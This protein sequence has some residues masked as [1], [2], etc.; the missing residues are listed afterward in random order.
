MNFKVL[1]FFVLAGIALVFFVFPGCNW[2]ADNPMFPRAKIRIDAEVV[3]P[4]ASSEEKN[5][6]LV[7]FTFT[8]LN[9]VGARITQYRLEYRKVDG[10]PLPRLASTVGTN[11]DII[12]PGTPMASNAGLEDFS[13]IKEIDLLPPDVEAYLKTNRIP[14]VIVTVT[15]SGVD[16]A[17]H[18]VSYRGGEFR[19]NVFESLP[20]VKL[21]FF[22]ASGD[23]CASCPSGSSVQI[24][25]A[26]TFD[27]PAAA[28]A[29][30]KVEFYLNGKEAGVDTSP[31]F[32][33]ET[34]GVSMYDR[35]IGTAVIYDINGGVSVVTNAADV[36]DVCPVPSPS[37]SP[38]T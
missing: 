31:P 11:I 8:P 1:S 10:T 29:V 15:F 5:P 22:C 2:F 12:P 37:P 38:G 36:S 17:S 6:G 25:C 34:V 27:N 26:L 18:P 7:R 21:E 13:V 35:V 20:E 9:M 19:L 23:S 4:S 30:T 3:T 33:S 28:A 14:A 24:G 16:Y 32:V